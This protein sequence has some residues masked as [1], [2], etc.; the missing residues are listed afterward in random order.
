MDLYYQVSIYK[1]V[2][3]GDY[4]LERSQTASIPTWEYHRP[5]KATPVK[6]TNSSRIER[7]LPN[8]GAYTY[9]DSH[10]HNLAETTLGSSGL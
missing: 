4:P 3:C 8:A 10:Y 6:T 1:A 5:S 7:S 9:M 2:G